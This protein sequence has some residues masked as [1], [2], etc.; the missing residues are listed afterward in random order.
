MPGVALGVVSLVMAAILGRNTRLTK[1]HER[2]GLLTK[3]RRQCLISG[4]AHLL[5]T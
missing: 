1:T 2:R 3:V 4:N 5:V